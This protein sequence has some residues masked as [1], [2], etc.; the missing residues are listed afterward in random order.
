MAK[1]VLVTTPV[2]LP[3]AY[4]YN[5]NNTQNFTFGAICGTTP[6]VNV[7]FLSQLAKYGS[8][9]I[10]RKLN[11]EKLVEHRLS[12]TDKDLFVGFAAGLSLYAIPL[13]RL[14]RTILK[15]IE[16]VLQNQSGTIFYY[17]YVIHLLHAYC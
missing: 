13:T 12:N 14:L 4:Y 16:H 15:E 6:G 3:G 10:K 2:T 7:Y 17:S 5:K 8:S 9:L 1:A 11:K